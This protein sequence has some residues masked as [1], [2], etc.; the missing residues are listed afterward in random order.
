MKSK[1]GFSVILTP[2]ILTSAG[3]SIGH[4]NFIKCKA[5]HMEPGSYIGHLNIIKGPFSV[6]FKE[7]GALGNKNKL[8]RAPLGVT[9]GDSRLSIG[10]LSKITS[11][12]YID[13]TR[14]ITFGDYATLAGINSQIWTHGYVHEKTG[15]GRIRVD[16]ETQIGNNVYIGSGCIFNPG[17][18]IK[19]GISVGSGSILSKPL[20][21]PG[22]YVNQ[23]LRYFEHDVAVVK[24]KLVKL[25]NPSVLDEV[26]V[27]E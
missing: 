6:Y 14:S 17:I 3:C 20:T 5:I 18:S 7:R 19:D 26:Y 25:N 9:Y 23:P 16:G 27:K 10:T 24:S 13:L 2:K 21:S 12:H 8:V 4:F 15:P 1:I 22:M 11:G